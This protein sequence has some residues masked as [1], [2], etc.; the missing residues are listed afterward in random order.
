[1]KVALVICPQAH[2]DKPPLSLAY[3]GVYWQQRNIDVVCFDF[4]IDL[5]HRLPMV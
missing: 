1:M 3:L 2:P 5:Y 4:N